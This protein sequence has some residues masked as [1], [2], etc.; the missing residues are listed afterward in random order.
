[1]LSNIVQQALTVEPHAEIEDTMVIHPP[2]TN[3]TVD[4]QTASIS[5]VSHLL[6]SGSSGTS[7]SSAT[8]QP[9]APVMH[10]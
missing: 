2:D 7:G 6:G 8:W 4:S 1:M 3:A 10:I 5:I 9:W